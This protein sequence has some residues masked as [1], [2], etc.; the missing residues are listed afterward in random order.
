MREE[1]EK[2]DKIMSIKEEGIESSRAYRRHKA[3]IEKYAEELMKVEGRAKEIRTNSDWKQAMNYFQV[4]GARGY[5]EERP[6]M[7]NG[8][9]VKF[10]KGAGNE[11]I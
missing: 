5:L 3:T 7:E 8:Y 6:T 9:K 1:G 11:T 2:V 4:L 10:K